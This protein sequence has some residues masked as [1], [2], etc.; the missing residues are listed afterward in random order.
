ML[1]FSVIN[2]SNLLQHSSMAQQTHSPV[3]E[4]LMSCR[5]DSLETGSRRALLALLGVLGMNS[6]NMRK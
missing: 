5:V 1:R 3:S 4:D 6:A 2:L